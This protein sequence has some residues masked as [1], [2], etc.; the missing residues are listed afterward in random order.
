MTILERLKIELS[1]KD[2]FTDAEYEVLLQENNLIGTDAYS[3]NTHQKQLLYTVIDVLE[4]VSNDVDLMRRVQ[5]EFITTGDAYKW[6][7]QRIEDI[8]KRIATIP[9]LDQ[10]ESDNTSFSLMFTRGM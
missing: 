7:Q 10:A 5:T 6:L 3:K 2:Y 4:A 8:R 9:T 1:N